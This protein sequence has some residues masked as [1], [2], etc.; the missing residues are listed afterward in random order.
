MNISFCIFH[1]RPKIGSTGSLPLS[2]WR[3]RTEEALSISGIVSITSG[4]LLNHLGGQNQPLER[5]SHS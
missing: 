5:R 1:L 2:K 3:S 4:L